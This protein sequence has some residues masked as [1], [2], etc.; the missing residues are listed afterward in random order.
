ML[1]LDTART[2]LERIS[3]EEPAQFPAAVNTVFQQFGLGQTLVLLGVLPSLRGTAQR[4][5]AVETRLIELETQRAGL[6]AA[7]DTA[8][9]TIPQLRTRLN[10]LGRYVTDQLPRPAPPAAPDAP[11][12]TRGG[13]AD[14]AAP[15]PAPAPD[16]ASGDLP[17]ALP[18]ALPA[19]DAD[20]F[21]R[22]G[23]PVPPPETVPAEAD[24]ADAVEPDADLDPAPVPD[25]G[26]VPPARPV[27]PRRSAP[28][29]PSRRKA[30]K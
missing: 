18:A 11:P 15:P 12:E 16:A 26:P 4:V 30:D 28:A 2:M 23:V 9:D 6:A 19:G 22:R 29:A 25:L 10:Q 7:L 1:T 8:T 3:R 24:A 21:T 27:P 13:V 14:A 20:W 5:D 17:A